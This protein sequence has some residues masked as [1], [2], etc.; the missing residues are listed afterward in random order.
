MNRCSSILLLLLASTFP[1]AAQ[2]QETRLDASIPPAV[3]GVA[4]NQ[5]LNGALP[6]ELPLVDSLGRDVRLGDY[7]NDKPVVLVPAYY[8]C[9]TLCGVVINGMASSLGV[10]KFDAGRDFDVVVYSF[11]P[12]D[13][14]EAALSRKRAVLTRYQR[15]GADDG[16]HFL[17]ASQASIDAL[18]EAIGLQ[19]KWDDKLAQYVHAAGA[20]VATADGRLSRYFYGKEFAARDLRLALVESSEGRIGNPVDALLL[21][22]YSYDPTTGAYGAVVMNMVRVAGVATI[23]GLVFMIVAFRLRELRKQRKLEQQ[24]AG[25]PA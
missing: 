14:P 19:I 22:C 3:E 8:S 16:W 24:T 18:N 6:L 2:L 9:P 12:R 11:D 5:R 15:E 20:I 13:T 1:A 4:L 23:L 21:Y 10:L 17:T 7:F 25:E